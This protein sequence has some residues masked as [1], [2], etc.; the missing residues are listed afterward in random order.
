MFS[1]PCCRD[2]AIGL[3]TMV[4]PD[5]RSKRSPGGGRV[6]I[7]TPGR[8]NAIR[9]APDETFRLDAASLAELTP[10]ARTI[11]PRPPSRRDPEAMRAG[12]SGAALATS[13][14]KRTGG[15]TRPTAGAA[16]AGKVALLHDSAT[17]GDRSRT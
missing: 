9:P 7:R 4:R 3:Q 13:S 10:R 2:V 14:A 8:C 1:R 11:R 6:A 12:A 15:D 16:A 5:T 17:G